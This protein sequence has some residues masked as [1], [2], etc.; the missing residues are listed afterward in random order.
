MDDAANTPSTRDAV[1]MFLTLFGIPIAVFVV[2]GF[3][4]LRPGFQEPG[5]AQ[6]TIIYAL[7]TSPGMVVGTRYV[8]TKK[9]KI[10][11]LLAYPLACL[12]LLVVVWLM[13]GCWLTNVC[14]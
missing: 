11:F 2:A 6:L 8:D 14:L 4:F 1:L 10:Q 7:A 12:S 5:W 9:E 13:V 3:V